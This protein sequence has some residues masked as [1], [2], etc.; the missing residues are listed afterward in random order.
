MLAPSTLGVA[1]QGLDF[2]GDP[3]MCRP[4]TLLGLPAANVPAYRRTD[5]LPVGLQV[6]GLTTSDRQFL[7]LL[8]VL[9]SALDRKESR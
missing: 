8:A 1:P 9:A 6:L 4:W 2:T 5:G 3:V 7:D